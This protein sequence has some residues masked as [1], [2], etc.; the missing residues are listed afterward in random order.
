M[1]CL[2]FEQKK[3]TALLLKSYNFV[4]ITY[5]LAVFAGT[6]ASFHPTLG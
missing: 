1:S 6:S 4:Q 2:N 5:T 3:F